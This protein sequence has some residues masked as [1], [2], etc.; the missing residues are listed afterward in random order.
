MQFS[1]HPVLLLVAAAATP[2]AAMAAV[3]EKKRWVGGLRPD[4]TADEVASII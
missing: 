4:I 1:A 2:H 3:Q